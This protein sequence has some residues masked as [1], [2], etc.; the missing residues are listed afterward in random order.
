[1]PAGVT[2][3]GLKAIRILL[4]ISLLPLAASAEMREAPNAGAA[5]VNQLVIAGNACGPA[6]LLSAFRCGNADWNLAA[7]ALPG[8]TDRQK[9]R[10]M[11]LKVAMR[12]SKHLGGRPRW[13]KS[14]VNVADLC[15]MANEMSQGRFPPKVG[16]EVLFL[17]AKESPEKLLGRVHNRF[18]E[19]L[20]KGFPPVVSIRRFAKRKGT[21]DV[22]EGHF[23]TVIATPRKLGRHDRSFPVTYL[24]PWGGKRFEGTIAISETAM[25]AGAAGDPMV[26][27]CLE[28][29]FPHALVGKSK[30][31]RGEP[32]FIS[33]SA[34]I[35]RW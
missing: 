3:K 26:P 17:R 34:M 5:P 28:A 11:I 10:H 19:S 35:G 24:D 25:R 20:A 8:E 31:A 33:V 13:S 21:W 14:G 1:M 27:A 16:Y 18:E 6:A 23:V 2:T 30:V 12:P 4:A 22:V 15:D 32:T 29:V 7:E 9:L